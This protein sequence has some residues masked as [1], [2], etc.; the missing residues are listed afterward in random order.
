MEDVNESSLEN[1]I[2]VTCV[3]NLER[4]PHTYN[5]KVYSLLLGKSLQNNYASRIGFNMNKLPEGELF[6][7]TTKIRSSIFNNLWSERLPF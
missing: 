3:I 5:K 6:I 2:T 1:N 7:N 4:S